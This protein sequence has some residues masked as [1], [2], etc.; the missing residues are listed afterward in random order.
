PMFSGKTEELI[1]RLRR[2]TFA[3]KRILVVRP[4]TD[5]RGTRSIFD[6]IKGD[7]KLS[8]YEC[9]AS[10]VLNHVKELRSLVDS[11]KPD[12]LAIDEAQFFGPELLEYLDELLEKKKSKNFTI[13]VAG[14]DMDAWR[15]PFGTMP[16]LLAMADEVLKLTAICVACNGENPAIFT[17]KKGGTGKQVEVGDTGLYEARCRACYYVPGQGPA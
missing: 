4:S 8:C 17:Q 11:W 10:R 13:I 16:Q 3:R 7:D 2:A 9:L 12:I 6:L 15:R 14:L 5:N 1:R